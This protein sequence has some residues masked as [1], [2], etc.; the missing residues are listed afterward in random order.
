MLAE[1]YASCQ[2]VFCNTT[3]GLLHR[4]NIQRSFTALLKTTRKAIAETDEHAA[5]NFPTIRFHDLRHTAAT[6][7]L[8][9]NIN[10]KVVSETL[11]HASIAITLDLYCHNDG[12]K[13]LA[14][15]RI[16]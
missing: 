9:A 11:G 7:M 2:F 10:P 4:P 3:G 12:S 13:T 1:G 6:L 15:R 5:N 14:F 16:L 8:S